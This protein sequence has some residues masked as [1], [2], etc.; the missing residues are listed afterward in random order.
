MITAD[1]T[2]AFG[3]GTLKGNST[4]NSFRMDI[5]KWKE[6]CRKSI[7][8]FSHLEN[9][10]GG[11]S[12]YTKPELAVALSCLELLR[13][14]EETLGVAAD[15]SICADMELQRCR[16]RSNGDVEMEVEEDGPASNTS[17]S[18]RS[19]EERAMMRW[20][21]SLNTATRA[22]GED[23]STLGL[24]M[25]PVAPAPVN[26]DALVTRARSQRDSVL[27]SLDLILDASL[28]GAATADRGKGEEG[29]HP[30]IIPM[31]DDLLGRAERLRFYCI[32]CRW[33]Q[34][35]NLQPS[36]G[37]TEEVFIMAERMRGIRP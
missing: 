7:D 12:N 26:M 29:D 2:A 23:I 8:G 4:N 20:G 35:P 9:S 27:H 30:V 34:Q 3:L 24:L 37:M 6:Q 33:E 22:V 15:A 31:T 36:F 32:E 11:C 14:S 1:D 10:S 16:E 18:T 25:R 17:T 13:A 5:A 28:Y 19:T 21:Q